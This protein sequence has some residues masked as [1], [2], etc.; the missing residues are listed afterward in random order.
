MKKALQH[1]MV[2]VLLFPILLLGLWIFLVG[3]ETITELM[4]AYYVG[5]SYQRGY[6]AG[7]YDRMLTLALGLGW[8]VLFVVS[9]ELLRRRVAKGKMLKVFFRFMGVECFLVLLIDVVLLIFLTDLST[10]GWTRW[11]IVAGELL[12]GIAFT[13]LG[14]SRRSPWYEKRKPGILEEQPL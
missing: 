5:H 11:L 13:F 9:E 2:Y 3:R 7:F 10:I 8:L 14:W 6:Q 4:R 12:G 1:I